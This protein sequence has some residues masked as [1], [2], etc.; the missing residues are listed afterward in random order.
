MIFLLFLPFIALGRLIRRFS[1]LKTLK[2]KGLK[3]FFSRKNFRIRKILSSFLI[4]ILTLFILF[5]LV[6]LWLSGYAGILYVPAALLDIVPSP[7]PVVV[8]GMS[9]LP[10]LK[11]GELDR[12]YLYNGL[13]S[14]LKKP[15]RGDIIT[16]KGGNTT[17]KD[18]NVVTF[19]KRV[20]AISGDEIEIKDGFL[21]INGKIAE[22]PY[23]L[24]P[25][26]TFGQSFVSDCQQ[27]KVPDGYVF[28]MGDNRNSS[29]DSRSMGFVSL[30][31]IQTFLPYNK[32][33]KFQSRWRDATHDQDSA[34][35]ASFDISSYYELFNK[36]RE[37]NS[38][39]PLK[40]NSKLEE[41]A[42]KRAWWIINNN[43]L[44]KSPSDSKYTT[45]KSQNESGYSNI[46]S[47]EIDT[48]GYFDAQD[49]SNYWMEYNTKQFVL[50]KDYQDTG[51]AAVV[52]RINGC[53]TQ[54]IVQEFGGYVPPNYS[55]DIVN[56][57]E[58]TL[59]QLKSILPSWEKIKN[60]PA[61]YSENKQDADR[62][63][64][65]INL[66]ISRIEIIVTKMRSGKW[67]TNEENSWTYEDE[68][69][70]NEQE[71]IAN[72]LNSLSWH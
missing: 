17:D 41:A 59:S 54:V 42:T 4:L 31:E 65:I 2:N 63:I 5:G 24:K 40:Q 12:F 3:S 13:I 69:L 28:A 11:D 19:V 46:V 1:F 52:G 61:T 70:Y 48:Y 64:E 21:Y 6:P 16:F 37:E 45:E 56:S 20:V 51:I 7:F 38:L 25:R 23:T 32:Q 43:E 50:N 62:L 71:R 36:K 72:K 68:S 18:K 67:L 34:G 57:W 53:D 26:S 49:L 15:Q 10:T 55:E 9:M 29:E 33:Q 66:R 30:N 27:V 47:G 8:K 44:N 22:E 14:S 58:I 35:L 39:K 60:F